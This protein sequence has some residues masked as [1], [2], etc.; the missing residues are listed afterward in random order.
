MRSFSAIVF[1]LLSSALLQA[2]EKPLTV[3][4]YTP[5]LATQFMDK[6]VDPCVDFYK[7]ACGNWNKLNPIPADQASWDGYGKVADESMRC[8]WGVLEQAAQA[9][10]RNANEQKIGD[11][12]HACMNVA[13][14]DAADA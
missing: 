8:L 7:Y 6:S 9:K 12:F 5:S 13:A 14:I 2:Q 11:Y 10:Y 4:P 3:L 1:L